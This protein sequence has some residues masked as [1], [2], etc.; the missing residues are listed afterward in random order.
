[1]KHIKTRLTEHHKK[2]DS[3]RTALTRATPQ[4]EER[5]GNQAVR[6]SYQLSIT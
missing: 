2:S 5:E 4:P 6:D 3:M 1:V